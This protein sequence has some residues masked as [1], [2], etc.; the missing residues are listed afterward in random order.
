MHA[1]TKLGSISQ[2]ETVHFLGNLNVDFI[3]EFSLFLRAK[4]F[5]L[6]ENNFVE[7]AGNASDLSFSGKGK[8]NVLNQDFKIFSCKGWAYP[9][10]SEIKKIY[11][12][13]YMIVADKNLFFSL[14]GTMGDLKTLVYA[15]NF[16]INDEKFSSAQLY[17]YWKKEQRFSGYLQ[18]YEKDKWFKGHVNY[19]YTTGK[20]GVLLNACLP[21]GLT[22]PLKE[23]LPHWWQPFFE[24]FQFYKQYPQTNF[25]FRWHKDFRENFLYGNV[26][27]ND[28]KYKNSEAKYLNLVFG[29]QPGYCL[30]DIKALKTREGEGYCKIHWPYNLKNEREE[31]WKIKGNGKFFVNT[32]KNFVNDFV[33]QSYCNKIAE[34]FQENSLAKADFKGIFYREQNPKENLNLVVRIPKTVLY[35]F[36]LWDLSFHYHWDPQQFSIETLQG[37]LGKTSPFE[38]HYICKQKQFSFKMKADSLQTEALLQHPV[39]KEWS[40]AIPEKNRPTYTGKLDLDLEGTGVFEKTLRL[41]GK[42][43]AQFDN[44]Q[45]SQIHLLGPLQNLFSKRFKWKPTIELDHLSSEFT[46]TEKQI[47]SQNTIISGPSTRANVSGELNLDNS[48]LNAQVYFSFLDYQQLRFPIMKQLFQLFQPISKGFAASVKG[49]FENPQ[50]TLTFNPFRF[51]LPQKTIRE[52]RKKLA[53]QKRIKSVD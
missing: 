9:R 17:C 6:G 51:V 19:R 29:Y 40:Y 8:L 7:F 11:P 31:Y 39:L 26:S 53:L 15:R 48:E 10:F 25:T 38:G 24:N 14:Y 13:P 22:Y 28:F 42:G 41:S 44:P 46:F 43:W 16:L 2:L 21:P 4:C 33:E 12:V 5:V 37:M 52:K 20:G 34:T 45:L 23:I 3:Q 49:T 32:W 27:A 35:H 47:L 50:W 30:L 36:P 18:F 1:K